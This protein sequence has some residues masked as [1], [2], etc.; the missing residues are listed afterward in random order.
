MEQDQS[1]MLN[2]SVFESTEQAQAMKYI[3][4]AKQEEV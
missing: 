2:Y 4:H 3:H 1:A